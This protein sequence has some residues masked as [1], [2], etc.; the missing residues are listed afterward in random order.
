MTVKSRKIV[1]LIF[2]YR[3]WCK[4][5]IQKTTY[6]HLQTTQRTLFYLL[7]YPMYQTDF[8][9]EA[10][11][12]HVQYP[13]FGLGMQSADLYL[14]QKSHVH[15][16][17]LW[18]SMCISLQVPEGI[19]PVLLCQLIMLYWYT[20]LRYR[21]DIQMTETCKRYDPIHVYVYMYRGHS[22]Q[23]PTSLIRP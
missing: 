12:V 1:L 23:S 8:Q 20:T 11:K 21:S 17:N 5:I 22:P 13:Y 16:P 4:N 6:L 9:T 14:N 19:Y 10:C 3:V 7:Y 2:E 15:S 18:F